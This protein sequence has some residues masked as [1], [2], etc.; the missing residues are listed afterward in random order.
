ME[1]PLDEKH[2]APASEHTPLLPPGVTGPPSYTCM[3]DTTTPA[4]VG[5]CGGLGWFFGI[6]FALAEISPATYEY[7]FRKYGTPLVVVIALYSNPVWTS[8]GLAAAAGLFAF[9]SFVAVSPEKKTVLYIAVGYPLVMFALSTVSGWFNLAVNATLGV[10]SKDPRWYMQV[11]GCIGFFPILVTATIIV[12]PGQTNLIGYVLGAYMS[13]LPVS[14]MV[15]MRFGL[16]VHEGDAGEWRWAKRAAKVLG[17]RVRPQCIRIFC[18]AVA[19][20]SLVITPN[21]L[22]YT[23]LYASPTPTQLMIARFVAIKALCLLFISFRLGDKSQIDMYPLIPL[24][25]S[26]LLIYLSQWILER[27][28]E[29]VLNP[30]T[31][32]S[33][34]S[35]SIPDE[36]AYMAASALLYYCDVLAIVLAIS[37]GGATKGISLKEWLENWKLASVEL[38]AARVKEKEEKVKEDDEKALLANLANAV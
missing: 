17:H 18:T 14:Y 9:F 31:G 4:D 13:F 8:I 25:S 30:V 7:Y 29:P 2:P 1:L 36:P 5:W 26:V 16:P 24:A 23:Y 38:K 21:V 28:N 10:A 12:L 27:T 33:I 35:S 34:T 37:D 22:A 19:V 6:S 32:M 3:P 15:H 20:L 11:L